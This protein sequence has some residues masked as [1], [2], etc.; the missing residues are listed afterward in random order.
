MY[1]EIVIH[2]FSADKFVV[3]TEEGRNIL[4]NQSTVS[5]IEIL[6]QSQT[7]EEAHLKF[8]E[9][10]NQNIDFENFKIFIQDKLAFFHTPAEGKEYRKNQYLKLR[11]PLLNA[12]IAGF[13][14]SPFS[15]LY[16]PVLF[17]IV[18]TLLIVLFVLCLIF[19]PISTLLEQKVDYFTGILL[20]YISILF[21]E[22]G[23]IAAC[24]KAGVKHGEVGFGFYAIFPVMY[25]DITNIWTATKQ[26]RIIGNLGGIYLE[27]LYASFFLIV[28]YFT[29]NYTFLF[30]YFLVVSKTF[31]ELNPFIRSDG[32]WL[33]S[34][35]SN[36]PN[37]LKKSNQVLKAV[38]K[39]RNLKNISKINLKDT[40]FFIY[41]L[42]NQSYLIFFAYFTIRNYYETILYFPLII[43]DLLFKLVTFTILLDDFKKEYIVV[44]L[45]YF[46]FF[47]YTR[48]AIRNYLKKRA[49]ASSKIRSSY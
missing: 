27:F 24:R 36:T 25:A 8:Q 28:Y 5:L 29:E 45:F 4:V 22:L 11:M 31:F 46:L 16:T 19:V 42:V 30:V 3:H 41:A 7:Q 13:L 6:Q 18:F 10:F 35:L 49:D 14:A 23:H 34:D 15:F 48:S 21:H 40:L 12:G 39:F 9:T 47:N 33:L 2:P 1:Q 37:L 44:A 17:Y 32:Y 26:Q 20:F 43:A 38:F